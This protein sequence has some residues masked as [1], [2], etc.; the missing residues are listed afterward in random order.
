MRFLL[1]NGKVRLGQKV[2]VTKNG[3]AQGSAISPFLFNI[4]MVG[5]M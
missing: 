3:V 5:L 4:S 1:T 2:V